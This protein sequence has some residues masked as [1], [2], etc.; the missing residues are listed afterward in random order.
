MGGPGALDDEELP[1]LEEA[2]GRTGNYKG[3]TGVVQSP[4][5]WVRAEL[6]SLLL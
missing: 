5:R 3:L 2:L 4:I 1:G 6:I